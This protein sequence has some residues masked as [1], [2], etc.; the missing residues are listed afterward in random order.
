[1][2]SVAVETPA[3]VKQARNGVMV[4]SAA[5]GAVSESTILRICSR[6]PVSLRV[7]GAIPKKR[8]RREELLNLEGEVPNGVGHLRG[9]VEAADS[10]RNEGIQMGIEDG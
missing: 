5:V 10:K 4:E 6:A 8:R 7:I 2:K 1:M 3:A 9:A